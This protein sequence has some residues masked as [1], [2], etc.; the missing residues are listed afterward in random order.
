[1]SERDATSVDIKQYISSDIITLLRENINKI[2]LN[3]GPWH[4]G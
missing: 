1:M 3:L 2:P 4:A